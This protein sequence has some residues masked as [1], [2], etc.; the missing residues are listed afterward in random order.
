MLRRSPL[1]LRPEIWA[2]LS[3]L[4]A[5]FLA[6]GC[7]EDTTAPTDD[8]LVLPA[9]TTPENVI[10]AIEVIYNDKTHTAEQRLAGYASLFPDAGAPLD[11][12]FLFRFQ[13]A[14][15]VHGLPPTWGLDQELAAHQ[16]MFNAQAAG[17]IYSIE[18][19]ITHDPARA[20]TP[21]QVGREG[22][23]EVFATNV[24]LRL[25]F[26]QDDGIEVNG[27]Q[28][29]FEFPP[30]AG[31]SQAPRFWISDWTDLPRPGLERSAVEPSTWGSIK[32]QYN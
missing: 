31:R 30:A 25:M 17:Q 14:D 21:P 8:S 13:P 28:A 19:R 32:A 16:A 1:P 12:A 7:K 10:S 6:A 26:N 5:I 22:W 18:L 23:Q 29:E 15:I 27:A 2:P 9:L 20:L 3:L 11:Q 24:Y 4:I